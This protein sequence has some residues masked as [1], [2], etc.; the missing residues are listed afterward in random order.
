ML[1][2]IDPLLGNDREIGNY[3]TA[4]TRQLPVNS[5]RGTLFS[6]RSV[7]RCYK[8]NEWGVSEF[9]YWPVLSS[10]RAPNIN[11]PETVSQ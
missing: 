4:V 8:Q 9:N 3:T 11:K 1:W 7:P 10:E 2:Y 5:N 6:V